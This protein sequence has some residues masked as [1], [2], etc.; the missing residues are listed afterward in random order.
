LTNN[1]GFAENHFYYTQTIVMKFIL[2]LINGCFTGILQAQMALTGNILNI[3]A[4]ARVL[5]NVPKGNWYYQYNAVEIKPGTNG[6]FSIVVPVQQPQTFRLD[7]G[8]SFLYLYAEPN[9]TL[10]VQFNASDITNTLQ[11]GG[12]L[13]NEN[14]FRTTTGL[15]FYKLFPETWNDSVSK[16]SAILAALQQNQQLA[17][18]QLSHTKLT[19]SAS[20]R[21]MT[22]A[23]ITYFT[24]SKLWE[25][26]FSTGAIST[27]PKGPF[28]IKEWRPTLIKAYEAQPLSAEDALDS[29]HYQQM[30]SYYPRYLMLKESS[31]DSTLAL[32][33]NVLGVPVQDVTQELKE[34]RQRYFEYKALQYGLTGRSLEKAIASF[35]INGIDQGQL[36]YLTEVY[37]AFVQRF[38]ASAYLELVAQAMKPYLNSKNQPIKASIELITDTT[39]LKTLTDIIARYPGKV[40]YLDMWGTWCGACREEFAY[41][42][43][44][45]ERYKNKPV[46]FVFVAIEKG[47]APEKK[48]IETV[49]FYN[50][51]GKHILAGKA[52]SEHFRNL[53]AKEES[54]LF[55]SYLL[56][57]QHGQLVTTKAKWPSS[58]EGLAKQI[59]KL[60]STDQ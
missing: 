19:L 37:E 51:R 54:M 41:Y 57:D 17:Q 45:Q 42:R 40:I 50:L 7:Y 26:M 9:K 48:W 47:T 36:D 29:Y 5:L 11:F 60:L 33:A 38:P 39:H 16:P 27:S 44:L 23:D 3:Q 31:R 49:Q 58:G 28:G 35:I 25:I 46:E 43:A 1:F 55:P 10:S 34:K 53:Y 32:A 24:A 4:G 13:G 8:G 56:I 12:Q 22:Q 30:I 15:T 2:L 20:F 6:R 52:L 21:R 18:E 14:Q 59:D